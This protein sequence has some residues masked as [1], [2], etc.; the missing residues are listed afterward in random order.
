MHKPFYASGFL[1]NLK[2]H[3]ILLLQPVQDSLP[4]WS[5]IK[6]ES[7]EGEE[8]PTTFKRMI[9]EALNL[10]LQPKNI[11]PIYDYVEDS[12][13][14]NFVFYAEVKKN[15]PLNYLA[16][17]TLSWVKFSDT[18]K[19]LFTARTKQDLIVGERVI[20]ANWRISQ[21]LYTSTS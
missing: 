12:D 20:N 13:K 6:T 19:L 18:L 8:A 16:K 4:N 14:E 9:L 21:D 2:T 10:N 15:P 1:Y 11:F 7:K 5:M 3:Q 17:T